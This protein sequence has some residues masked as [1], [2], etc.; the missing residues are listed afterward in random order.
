MTVSAA[1]QL[2]LVCERDFEAEAVLAV[3]EKRA[4]TVAKSMRSLQLL[5]LERTLQICCGNVLELWAAALIMCMRSTRL[6]SME[7][8]TLLGEDI[9]IPLCRR[10]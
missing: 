2:A 5:V 3:V 10:G 1:W 4:M 9:G 8:E 7:V 6:P